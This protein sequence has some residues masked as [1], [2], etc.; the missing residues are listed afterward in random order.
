M[1]KVKT[2]PPSKHY[3]PW[4]IMILD[5]GYEG[6]TFIIAVYVNKRRSICNIINNMNHHITLSTH[7]Y[8]IIME[9]QKQYWI[10]FVPFSAIEPKLPCA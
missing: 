8:Y 2:L 9:K 4:D 1:L 3:F 7:L 6:Y 5:E 10:T